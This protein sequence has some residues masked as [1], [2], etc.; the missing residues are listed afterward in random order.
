VSAYFVLHGGHW[1]QL[2]M[3]EVFPYVSGAALEYYARQI[4]LAKNKRCVCEKAYW[5]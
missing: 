2:L 5:R 1:F 3:G 4:I